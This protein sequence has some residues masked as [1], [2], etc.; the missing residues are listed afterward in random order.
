MNIVWPVVALFGSIVA[1]WAYYAYGKLSAHSAMAPAAEKGQTPPSRKRTP[2]AMMVA[3]GTTHCGSGCT[4][5]DIIAEW[6]AFAFPAVAVWLGWK[7]VF[8]EKIFAVWVLDYILAFVIGIAFQYFT[9]KPMHG[10]SVGEG[11]VQAVKADAA[12]LTAWQ[13]GMYG[14]MA[15]AYFLIFRSVLGVDLRVDSVEFW[16]MMQIAMWFG[17]ATSYPVN[18][19]LIV[20]GIKEKM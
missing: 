18:W 20:S 3:K 10:L 2:F 15:V 9:I 16:F 7:S 8:P 12:S 17:F 13:I 14:F 11:L 19:W 6:L 1:L 5:G 4:I